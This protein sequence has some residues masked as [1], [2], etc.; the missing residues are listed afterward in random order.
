MADEPTLDELEAEM[1]REAAADS[2]EIETQRY[3]L[4]PMK[5]SPLRKAKPGRGVC[6]RD[7]DDE[8]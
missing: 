7:S 1:D 8:Y 5:S 3:S 4:D 6:D 2:Q